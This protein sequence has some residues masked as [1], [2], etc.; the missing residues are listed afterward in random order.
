MI[1]APVSFTK[2]HG[3]LPLQ[4]LSDLSTLS[5][6]DFAGPLS[7]AG[8]V[9]TELSYRKD[10]LSHASWSYNVLLCDTTWRIRWVG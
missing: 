8:V 7:I 1:L 5:R 3:D 4:G 6:I 10:A 9:I 2:Q